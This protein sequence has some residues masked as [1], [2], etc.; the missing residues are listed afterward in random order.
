MRLLRCGHFWPGMWGVQFTLKISASAPRCILKPFIKWSPPMLALYYFLRPYFTM[1]EHF[2]KHMVQRCIAGIL[3]L[4]ISVLPRINYD[5]WQLKWR[6]LIDSSS[7]LVGEKSLWL[8][9][10]LISFSQ[11]LS[12]DVLMLPGTQTRHSWIHAWQENDTRGF[13]LQKQETETRSPY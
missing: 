1:I 11:S 12:R 6:T 4:N 2:I 9:N 10:E 3:V 5:Q 7:R 8:W 13:F